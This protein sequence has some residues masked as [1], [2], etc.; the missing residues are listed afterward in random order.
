MIRQR[1]SILGPRDLNRD[2]KQE[3]SPQLRTGIVAYK[4]AGLSTAE[5]AHRTNLPSSTIKTTLERAP[6]RNNQQSNPRAGR[7]PILTPHAR[8]LILRL[9]RATPK[10]KYS[11]I[12][13]QTQL[14]VSKSTFYRLLKKEGI[15]NWIAKVRPFLSSESAAKCFQWG[16]DHEN[17]TQD[18]WKLIIFSDESS[19][20][21]G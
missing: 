11:E 1:R 13:I 18:Q 16:K 14:E 19:V 15:K 8:R 7:P 9:V 10:I 3:L 21:R 17:W 5:I 4:D 2:Y 6:S 12:C 20:E